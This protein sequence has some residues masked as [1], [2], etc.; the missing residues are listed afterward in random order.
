MKSGNKYFGRDE[1]YNS[2]IV[3]GHIDLI[4]KI[5]NIKNFESNPIHYLEKLIKF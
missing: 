3:E 1:H 2:V 4:G 5:K